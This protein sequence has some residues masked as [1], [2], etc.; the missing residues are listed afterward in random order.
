MC[1]F[2]IDI[3]PPPTPV[4][5][6]YFEVPIFWSYLGSSKYSNFASKKCKKN[7][8]KVIFEYFLLKW[9][10]KNY[11]F[12]KNKSF[13]DVIRQFSTKI[14]S[15]VCFNVKIPIFLINHAF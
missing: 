3:K 13:Y 11:V 9:Y 15:F 6:S 7:L 2:K 12:A 10:H 14:T 1:G 8:K 5:K 4:L